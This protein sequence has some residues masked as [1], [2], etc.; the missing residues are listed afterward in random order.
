MILERIASLACVKH[1]GEMYN[2]TSTAA[3]GNDQNYTSKNF[4]LLHALNELHFPIK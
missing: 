2:S 3:F 4:V 1:K